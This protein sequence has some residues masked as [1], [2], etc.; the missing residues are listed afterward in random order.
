M[1]ATV[2]AT[3]GLRLRWHGPALELGDETV[4]AVLVV[5]SAIWFTG[6]ASYIYRLRSR[7]KET[8]ALQAETAARDALTDL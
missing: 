6:A 7:L 4:T 5:A 8:V 3:V 1:L 2:A